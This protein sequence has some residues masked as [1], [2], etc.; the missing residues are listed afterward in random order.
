VST[1]EHPLKLNSEQH[2]AFAER[3][4]WHTVFVINGIHVSAVNPAGGTVWSEPVGAGSACRWNGKEIILT[5]RHVLDGAGPSDIRFFLR[6]SGRVDWATRP[7]QSVAAATVKLNVEDIIRSRSE[8]LACIVL[9]R[10]DL[11]RRVEFIDLP[12]SFGTPP[13]GGSGTLISGCPSDQIVPVAQTLEN[14]RTRRVILALQPVGC[15]A[16]IVAE[17]PRFFP[18]SFD[19]NRHFLLKYD[20]SE[21]GAQPFG[22]SGSG[23]WCQGAGSGEFWAARPVLAGVETSWHQPSNLMIAVRSEI[24]RQFLEDALG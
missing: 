24:V 8:D 3:V 19:P 7:S 11:E 14:E 17:P 1:V 16:V 21:E 6:P 15:W 22:Y 5:A 20:P 4:A 23:V 13:P 10:N 2:H 12:T 9:G 18:S